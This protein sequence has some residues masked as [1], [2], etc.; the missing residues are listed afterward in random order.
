MGIE[1]RRLARSGSVNWPLTVERGS[2]CGCT[3]DHTESAEGLL[4]RFSTLA[5]DPAQNGSATRTRTAAQE[6]D[7]GVDG[8]R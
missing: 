7:F 6:S 3:L 2:D 4:D 1:W 8:S 5:A